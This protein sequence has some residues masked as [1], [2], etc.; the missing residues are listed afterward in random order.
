ML[1]QTILLL[2]IAV[3]PINAGVYKCCLQDMTTYQDI[4]CQINAK[5]TKLLLMQSE[6]K[7]KSTTSHK[8]SLQ[9]LQARNSGKIE[10]IN[11]RRAKTKRMLAHQAE[12]RYNKKLRRQK[13]C[14]AIDSELENIVY[15]LNR[16]YT[17]RRGEQLKQRQRNFQKMRK[18]YCYG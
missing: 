7:V 17:V 4:P 5:Q 2:G 1:K 9:R 6:A 10:K 15:Y 8:L 11:R 3:I 12:I 18:I 14:Q 13:R 16:G